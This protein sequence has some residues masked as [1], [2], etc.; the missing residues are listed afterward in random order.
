MEYIKLCKED[1]GMDW[2]CLMSFQIV[3]QCI[4]RF[5]SHK[6][7]I[8]YSDELTQVKELTNVKVFHKFLQGGGISSTN[9]RLISQRAYQYKKR[10]PY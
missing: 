5:L 7:K 10:S 4:N 2:E 9:K 1:R 8:H 3:N 6:I